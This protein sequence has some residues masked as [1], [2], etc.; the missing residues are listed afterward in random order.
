MGICAVDAWKAF[1]KLV[2]RDKSQVPLMEFVSLVAG[3]LVDQGREQMVTSHGNCNPRE[4]P[5]TPVPSASNHEHTLIRFGVSTKDQMSG[6]TSKVIQKR[7]K[8]CSNVHNR[9]NMTSFF[10]PCQNI[11]LCSDTT[12]RDCF[13]R[14]ATEPGWQFSP[15]KFNA[16]LVTQKRKRNN[17]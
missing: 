13:L 3:E 16:T 10:C 11:A 2:V 17:K 7:C 6:D 14:H 5:E 8:F 12:D 4:D 1:N 15:T 9:R